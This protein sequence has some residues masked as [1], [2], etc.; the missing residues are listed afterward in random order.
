MDSPLDV[1]VT[2]V[3]DL[4]AATRKL[5]D[6]K[7]GKT[8]EQMAREDAGSIFDMGIDDIDHL[9]NRRVRTV[10][11]LLANVCRSGLARTERVV[12]ERMTFMIKESKVYHQASLLIQKL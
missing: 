3:E 8:D 4:V 1:R 9:G 10:G 11:E 6:L 2:T 5:T 7:R 12:R